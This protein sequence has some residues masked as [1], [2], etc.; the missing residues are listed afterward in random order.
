[1]AARLLDGI[2]A[3]EPQI[4]RRNYD[5][6]D[7]ARLI[8]RPFPIVIVI[9]LTLLVGCSSS[10][11]SSTQ[12]TLTSIKVTPAAP[13]IA[14]QGTQQF[15]AQGT[16]SDNSTQDLTASV[17]WSSSPTNVATINATGLAT[18]VAA[19]TATIT[20]TS[21]AVSG[22][23]SLT[24]NAAG[25]SSVTAPDWLEFVGD[26]S[27]GAYSCSGACSLQGEHWFSSFEVASGAKLVANSV[28]NPI[29]IRATGTCTVQGTISD[30]PHSGAGGNTGPGDF[31][32]GG[33]GGGAGANG[34]HGG[35]VSVGDAAIEIVDGGRGGTAPGGNGTSGGSATIG[36]YRTLLSGGT[37]WPVG[38][39]S[40]GQG[41]SN[42]GDGGV[43]GGVVVLVCNSISFTGT[44]D[45]SGAFGGNSPGTSSGAGGGGGGGYV[46]FS[47][48]TF[49]ANTGVINTAG[50]VGGT[51]GS[52]TSCGKGGSG[53]SGWNAAFTIPQ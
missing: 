36:E 48:V 2:S 39:S 22:T 24:V 17:Q 14:V 34:G 41:G 29:V 40:G 16:F 13:S 53:G 32:G 43:G 5:S 25:S 49:P 4:L 28:N 26:G 11:Q 21:G 8:R 10:P 30:S 35:N 46:I 20:A 42:G 33:G 47:A 52:D 12:L 27:E 15:A 3:R 44:I 31:G 38:G 18:A 7:M 37:F 1:M 23:A 51:C 9:T 45:V 50:G 19:G 6:R